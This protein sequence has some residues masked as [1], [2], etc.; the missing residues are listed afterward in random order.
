MNKTQNDPD[1]I[2]QS[3][4]CWRKLNHGGIQG[5]SI[6]VENQ[7]LTV[8]SVFHVQTAFY[9]CILEICIGLYNFSGSEQLFSAN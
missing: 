8:H 4:A 2:P 9:L 5:K 1:L 6:S 3:E 7:T